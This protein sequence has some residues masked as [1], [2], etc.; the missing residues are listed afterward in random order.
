MAYFSLGKF[1]HLHISSSVILKSQVMEGKYIGIQINLVLLNV[2][3]I[4]QPPTPPIKNGYLKHT[5][6]VYTSFKQARRHT[7][8]KF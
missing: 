7:H 4:P 2:W 3:F 5:F 8:W 6:N 1:V